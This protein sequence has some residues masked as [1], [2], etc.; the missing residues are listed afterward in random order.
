[1]TRRSR[2]RGRREAPAKTRSGSKLRSLQELVMYVIQESE[3]FT[4]SD[5]DGDVRGVVLTRCRLANTA[6]NRR[7]IA[8]VLRTLIKEKVVSANYIKKRKLICRVET[9]EFLSRRRMATIRRQR[10]KIRRS[11]ITLDESGM[12]PGSDM[13]HGEDAASHLFTFPHSINSAG[14]IWR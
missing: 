10:D 13:A 6:T 7:N 4:I 8:T 5:R 14:H 9:K 2:P 11:L 3:D 1:M 12:K